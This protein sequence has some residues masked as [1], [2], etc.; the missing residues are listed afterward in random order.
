MLT[1]ITNTIIAITA[2][3]EKGH[4]D[5]GQGELCVKNQKRKI[6]FNTLGESG[7]VAGGRV[8]AL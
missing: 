5:A 3:S 8:E 4:K 7:S 1:N 2:D 6:Y